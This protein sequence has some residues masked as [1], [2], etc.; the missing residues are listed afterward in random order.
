MIDNIKTETKRQLQPFLDANVVPDIILFENEGSDG[1]LFIEESTGHTRGTNDGKASADKINQE[2]CG[3]IPTGK[4]N[5]YPQYAGYLK[6]EVNACSE[7]ITAAG[8]SPDTTRYGLHSHGQYVQWK[9]GF[10]HGP[11]Q[12]SQSALLDSSSGACTGT[13]SIPTEILAQNV[14]TMMTIMGFSAYPTPMESDAINALPNTTAA[15]QN[16][17]DTLTQMQGYTE[18]WGRHEDGPFIGQYKLQALGVEYATRYK[19]D[20]NNAE[21][22]FTESM[23]AAVKN[24][25]VFLGLLW[26]EATYCYN[27]WMGGD[28]TMYTRVTDDPKIMGQAPMEVVKTWGKQAVSSWL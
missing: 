9:E 26:W 21:V 17:I 5:S 19:A 12:H 8:F 11:E 7:A 24:F 18:T 10:V 15:F 13:N 20:D 27:D 23:F 2:L 28:A 22:A 1:F 14:T 3:Q 25:E 16:I 6:A 4:M